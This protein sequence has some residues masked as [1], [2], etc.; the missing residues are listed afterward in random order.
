MIVVTPLEGILRED[1]LF[2][3]PLVILEVA[4]VQLHFARSPTADP[5]HCP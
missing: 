4:R 5:G 1:D 2:L 3:M